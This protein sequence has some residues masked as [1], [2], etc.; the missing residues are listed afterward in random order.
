MQLFVLSLL[1][2]SR[3]KTEENAPPFDVDASRGNLLL[4]QSQ[5]HSVTLVVTGGTNETMSTRSNVFLVYVLS[6]NWLLSNILLS[7]V[8]RVHAKTPPLS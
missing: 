5:S 6:I 7:V 2:H 3:N 8:R 1:E 4:G